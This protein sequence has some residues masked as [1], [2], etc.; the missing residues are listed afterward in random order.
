[1]I[2]YTTASISE[3]EAI[4]FTDIIAHIAI[5]KNSLNEIEYTGEFNAVTEEHCTNLLNSLN[6]ELMKKL[7]RTV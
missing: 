3:E 6:D 7:I 4:L 1:M 2:Y 5:I